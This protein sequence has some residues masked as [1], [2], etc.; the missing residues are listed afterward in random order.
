MARYVWLRDDLAPTGA[1][2]TKSGVDCMLS[3]RIHVTIEWGDCDPAGIVFYPRYFA[4]FDAAMSALVRHGFGITKNELLKKYDFAGFPLV[5]SR[6]RFI[7]P[8]KFGD[9]VVIETSIT[10]V[11]RSSFDLQHRV[12]RDEDLAVEGNETRVW[13]GLDP[14]DAKQIKAKPIPVEVVMRFNAQV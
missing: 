5:D 4:F 8:L 12:L 3:N 6:A 1:A 7:I 9:E 11:G 2:A 10:G 14:K 13:V